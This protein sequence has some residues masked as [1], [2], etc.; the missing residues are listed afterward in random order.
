M[1]EKPNV[2]EQIEQLA[3]KYNMGYLD[4]VL[5]FCEKYNVEIE[6]I[7]PII[8]RDS[9]FKW[10]LYHEFSSLNLV[11]KIKTLESLFSS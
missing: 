1:I 3:Q 10:K 8:K 7:A 2:L 6:A 9:E 5:Y 11:E 4:S